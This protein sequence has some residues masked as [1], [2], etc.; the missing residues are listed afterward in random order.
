MEGGRAEVAEA[1]EVM[2]GGSEEVMEGGSEEVMEGG[3]EEVIEGGG[4]EVDG[5]SEEVIE[6]G[7]EEVDGGSEEVGEG[8][9]EGVGEDE[10]DALAELLSGLNTAAG[11]A[12]G[13][14]EG[15][16][17]PDSFSG[18]G[19]S[20]GRSLQS[21]SPVQLANLVPSAADLVTPVRGSSVDTFLTG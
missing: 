14:G 5:G 1:E 17:Q 3:S 10:V 9:R 18:R 8:G 16:E 11:G 12:V 4:E 13:E 21:E 7:G 6:G 2:E 15:A 20:D 19:L